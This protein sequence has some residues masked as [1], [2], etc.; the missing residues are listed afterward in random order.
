MEKIIM[1]NAN[2]PF[3][4]ALANSKDAY[5]SGILTQCYVPATDSN[6]LYIGDAVKLATGS[7]TTEVLGHKPG[8]LPIVAKVA[9]TDKIDGVIVGVLP[10]GS[11]FISGAKPAS[12]EAV[13]FVILNPMARFNVQANGAVTAAMVG[14]YAT[15]NYGTE[16]TIEGYVEDVV[17]KMALIHSNI[18]FKFI[19]SKK[20]FPCLSI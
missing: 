17:G 5:Y 10:N 12:T 7:N 20:S 18:A 11:S 9:A 4:L 14:K 1:A 6:K 16:E 15:A 8:T 2:S 19:N 3:G 13:V